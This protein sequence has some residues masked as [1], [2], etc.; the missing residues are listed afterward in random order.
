MHAPGVSRIRVR[1]PHGVVSTSWQALRAM[2]IACFHD[3][4]RTTSAPLNAHALA[5]HVEGKSDFRGRNAPPKL[6]LP[7]SLHDQRQESE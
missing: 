5:A 4:R 3:S 1:V 2:R 7:E 6:P